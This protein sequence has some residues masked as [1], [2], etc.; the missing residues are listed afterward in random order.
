LSHSV[1]SWGGIRL[2]GGKTPEGD[3]VGEAEVASSEDL[4]IQEKKRNEELVT[5]M[6]YLQADFEN[7]RKRMEKEMQEGEELA[8]R[9]VVVRLL[10]VIDELELAVA[11]A[12]KPN[13]GRA[14]SDGIKM[15]YKNL[16]S[17]MKTVGLKRIEAVGMPFDPK[18]HEAVEKTQGSSDKDIVVGEIRS[19]YSF[20]GQVLRPSMVKVELASKKAGE[21]EEKGDE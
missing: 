18:L 20:R 2:S 1:R 21:Q 3:Q 14:V 15:V 17:V 12:E 11:N 4:L 13:Q 7:Y 10:S 9:G 6:K 16:N 8:V 19:G 5:K